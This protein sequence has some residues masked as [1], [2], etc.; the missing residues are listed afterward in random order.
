MKMKNKYNY[1]ISSYINPIAKE[2]S[3]QLNKTFS[4]ATQEIKKAILNAIQSHL[5]I[6]TLFPRI[7]IP[8]LHDNLKNEIINL[9]NSGW[10]ICGDF[11]IPFIQKI[12]KSNRN[13]INKQMCGFYSSNFNSIKGK[14]LGK[15]SERKIILDKAFKAHGQSDYELSI[16]VF[17]AQADG[18][19]A[20]YLYEGK[21]IFIDNLK[22]KIGEIIKER[23]ATDMLRL[24]LLS[25]L[26]ENLPIT[27]NSKKRKK[28]N[29]PKD[30]LNRHEI[31][32]GE[33]VTYASD[34]NSY[35]AISLLYYLTFVFIN[36]TSNSMGKQDVP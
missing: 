26:A 31:L 29:Y 18:I 21:S 2:I 17:L 22:G 4:I 24:V 33:S 14:I 1:Q 28:S 3:N 27:A 7:D 35:K 19:A 12:N 32:H 25:I 36:K 11:D 34:I 30:E 6:N 16:P 8:K 23:Y 9:A 5:K 20:K 15:F 13:E 10:Y